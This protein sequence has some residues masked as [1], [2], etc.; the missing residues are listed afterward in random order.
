MSDYANESFDADELLAGGG[1]APAISW[2]GVKLGTTV[3][4]VITEKPK[5]T[6]VKD[7][8][9]ND[10]IWE[11]SGKPVKQLVISLQTALRDNELLSE[12][13]AEKRDAS[14]DD[15]ARRLFVREGR[16]QLNPLRDAIKAVGEKTLAVGGEV[17]VTLKERKKNP[18]FPTRNPANV[19][20]YKY[21]PPKQEL[22]VVEDEDETADDSGAVGA[23]HERAAQIAK[24]K[25]AGIPD[26][27]IA[28][29]VAAGTL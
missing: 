9:G 28:S 1:G 16:N 3:K 19:F 10:K 12:N 11:N 25:A 6:V 5:V 2:K 18:D 14:E 7:D 29:M 27:V 22:V 24:L 21:V 4:G 23:D 13:Q 26:D 17:T 8:E 20:E 15:G